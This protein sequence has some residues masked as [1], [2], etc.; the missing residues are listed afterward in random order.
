MD[1][2][3]HERDH[4]KA[5]VNDLTFL[6]GLDLFGGQL[7]QQASVKTEVTGFAFAVVQVES[8]EF[9]SGHEQEDLQV[10]GPSNSAGGTVD[11]GV[12]VGLTGKVNASLLYKSS[13]NGKHADA[14]MLQ[15]R[16]TSVFQVGLDVRAVLEK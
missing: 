16:P 8:G 11:I 5:A 9:Q 13:N 15:F 7:G 2:L 10:G 6:T 12:G 3:S 1:S 4:G 14:S